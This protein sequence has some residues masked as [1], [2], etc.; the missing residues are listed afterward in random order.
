MWL[1]N[2]Y[3]IPPDKF[4]LVGLKNE[5]LGIVHTLQEFSLMKVQRDKDRVAREIAG[6]YFKSGSHG[7][8]VGT[9]P[10][11]MAFWVDND[12]TNISLYIR[13]MSEKNVACTSKRM[14]VTNKGK[15]I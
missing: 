7:V 13:V 12:C 10:P 1:V 4:A 2:I 8:L 3:L 14:K 6:F 11:Y 5:A 9:I 15:G